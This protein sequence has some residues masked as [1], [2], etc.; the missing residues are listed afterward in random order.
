VT[1]KDRGLTTRTRLLDEAER[2]F[3]SR[4]YEATSV[5]DIVRAAGANLG[6]ITYHFG[7]K[8][9][10]LQEV[11]ARRLEPLNQERLA[12]LEAAQERSGLQGPRLEEILEAAI[13]P[14]IRLLKEKPNFMRIIG[15]LLT[16]PRRT[17]TH[18]PEAQA[19]LERFMKAVAQAV[20]E[21]PAEELVWR[22][23]F[24]RGALIHTWTASQ[25][26]P[27]SKDVALAPSD[28]ETM[29]ARLVAF[30]AAGLRAP[31]PESDRSRRRHAVK[32]SHHD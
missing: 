10:L 24:L 26:H 16:S 3:A 19:L 1:Q 14:T 12:R 17:I 8:K 27:L 4:G 5:R 23:H 31:V 21:V 7:S 6:A 25:F 2:L 32:G 22:L 29:V 18:P 28:P 15:E 13:A 30:G 11:L 9:G 20:P